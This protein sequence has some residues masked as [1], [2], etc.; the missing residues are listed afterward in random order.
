L[1]PLLERMRTEGVDFL[2]TNAAMGEE[3]RRMLVDLDG[4]MK[5]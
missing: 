1:R 2:Q 4:L 3:V 5:N